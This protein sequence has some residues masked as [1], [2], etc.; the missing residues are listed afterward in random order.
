MLCALQAS[1][2]SAQ[3]NLSSGLVAYYPL[4][5]TF[6]DASGNGNHGTGQN[7]VTFGTDQWGN[8][9]N[10]AFFDGAND[11][12]TVPSNI[13]ITPS[14]NYTISFRFKTNSS[15]LQI[16]FSKSDWTGTSAPNN[17]QI[18][19]GINGGSLL[20]SN[21]LF[22]ATAH[23]GNTCIKSQF[24]ADHYSYGSNTATGTWYCVV[25]T[26]NNGVKKTYMNG[27]LVSTS[28][29]TGTPNNAYIDSCA[30]GQFRIGSWW[31]NDPRWFSGLIDEVR[32][33]KRTLNQPEI[34]SLCNLKT[35]AS[36]T[37]LNN[38]AAVTGRLPC[39]NTFIVDTATGFAA[40]DT[41]LMMQM[42]GAYIDSS[43]TSAFGK[44]LA[45]NNVGNYEYNIIQS[46]SGNNIMLRNQLTRGYD[47]PHGRVQFI[48]VP[49]YPAYTVSQPLTCL[50]WTG[51]KG[52]VFAIRTAGTL[53]LNAD[54]DVSGKGFR[55]GQPMLVSAFSCNKTDYF[56]PSTNNEGAQKGEGITELGAAKDYGRGAK[57]DAGGGGNDHNAGGG[58]GGGYAAG[59]LG[60]NQYNLG[61]C[62]V[63]ANIGGIGGV[64]LTGYP[65]KVFLG[66]G[67]GC[68]HGNNFG[69]KAGGTGGG[70]LFVDAPAIVGNGYS[71]RANGA[72]APECAAPGPFNGGCVDDGGG[73][74]G[75]AGIVYSTAASI[76]TSLIV[77]ARGGKGSNVYVSPGTTVVAP[78][79]GGGGGA[80]A[81]AIGSATNVASNTAGGLAGIAPQFGN[82]NHG[83]LAG[84]PGQNISSVAIPWTKSPYSSAPPTISFTYAIVSCNTAK[85]TMT[86]TGAGIATQLWNFGGG[87]TLTQPSPTFTFP[88]TG[89]FTV[90]LSIT[91]SNGCTGSVSL[92]VVITPYN[93][94]RKDTTICA[95]ESVTLGTF[96]GANSYVWSPPAGLSS[97]NTATTVATPSATTTYIVQVNAGPGCTYRDTFVV[98]VQP[99]PKADFSSSPSYPIPNK[100]IQ[101]SNASN[102]ATT[103]TW[104]FGDGETSSETS[105]GHLYKKTGSYRVCLIASNGT[106]CTDSVCKT[107]QADVRTAIGVASAFS[108]NGDGVNDV[109]LVHGAAVESMN[110]KIFNRWGQKVFETSDMERGWDGTFKG[111]AQEMETYA[112]L[113]IATFIDGSTTQ[114]KGNINLIR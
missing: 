86:S 96:P 39:S 89:T 80:W 52:G 13:G 87:S 68:G 7:G 35:S 56:Y 18:Q 37:I 25:L 100:P 28:T 101:F 95:G 6:N 34:D 32:M 83:A 77:E 16:F 12:I 59:G 42:K 74:G 81:A 31:Q 85:F 65:Q 88:G 104:T 38:Y 79:G 22:F 20:P 67:G 14:Y 26:F 70:I 30:N 103:Y 93:G 71:L 64:Q 24:Y 75:S 97:L 58:G 113:L 51:A 11:Y 8:A 9:N 50:P 66:G 10:A 36:G 106:S 76:T 43:N 3:V 15:A 91:D 109:L 47:I 110:L 23:T 94:S 60:G 82:S 112:Y 90:T 33:Y 69:E 5:G 72:A 46:V 62:A 40:G 63:T 29:V 45:Y 4:N 57:A 21:G 98:T 55:G 111:Q 102:N 49:F 105:P 78:G 1:R 84:S 114:Q 54:I 2:L 41:I 108:P 44:V 19:I 73:G 27:I 61:A 48:R 107:V 99:V 92:P 53:T 17:F